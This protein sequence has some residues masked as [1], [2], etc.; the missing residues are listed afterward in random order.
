MKFVGFLCA[1]LVSSL[2][3]R[4]KLPERFPSQSAVGGTEQ[5]DGIEQS[6]LKHCRG[7][8]S[9]CLFGRAFNYSSILLPL[10]FIFFSFSKSM[11]R[12]RC[13]SW[14]FKLFVPEL[15][16]ELQLLQEYFGCQVATSPM[17]PFPCTCTGQREQFRQPGFNQ[18]AFPASKVSLPEEKNH[19]CTVL[20]IFI[21]LAGAMA[22]SVNNLVKWM[23]DHV[24]W[25]LVIEW[26]GREYCKTQLWPEFIRQCNERGWIKIHEEKS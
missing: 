22:L 25:L 11:Y 10:L 3:W 7:K 8:I 1:G 13:H 12:S 5:I 2:S 6:A 14:N 15:L 18:K 26:D 24:V 9:F 23:S 19:F 20:I 17:C 16:G 21:S 4:A